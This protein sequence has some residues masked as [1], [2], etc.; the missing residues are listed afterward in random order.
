MSA[1]SKRHMGRIAQ[2]PCA[3]CGVSGVHVHHIRTGIGMGRRASDF[4]TLPLCPEHHQG[5][6]GIHGCGRKAFEKLHNVTELELL[7]RT[8]EEL[9]YEYKT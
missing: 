5:M 4:D 1:E 9:G 8:K 6:T 7:R 3:L 2:M